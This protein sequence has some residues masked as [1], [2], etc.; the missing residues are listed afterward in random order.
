MG[1]KVCLV[2]VNLYSLCILIAAGFLIYSCYL[3]GAEGDLLYVSLLD[4]GLFMYQ[5]FYVVSTLL[6]F[7]FTFL[8]SLC[9]LAFKRRFFDIYMFVMA[10]AVLIFNVTAAYS[11]TNSM[12]GYYV[13]SD[14]FFFMTIVSLII[15]LFLLFLSSF[16][17]RRR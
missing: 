15:L 16:V 17:L 6:V 9:A 3:D 2:L 12:S 7:L 10:I 13:V 5:N 14:F 8:I 1:R 4:I 11:I